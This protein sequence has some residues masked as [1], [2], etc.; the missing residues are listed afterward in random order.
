MRVF[1]STDKTRRGK[2]EA[3]ALANDFILNRKNKTKAVA[4][5]TEMTLLEA[6]EQYVEQKKTAYLLRP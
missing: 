5:K 1:T 3:E 2:V 6:I 4:Q